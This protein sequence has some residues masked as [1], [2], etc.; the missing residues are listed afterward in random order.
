MQVNSTE[1]QAILAIIQGQGEHEDLVTEKQSIDRRIEA[2]NK[3]RMRLAGLLSDLRPSG[4]TEA[5]VFATR[6]AVLFV[7]GDGA[8]KVSDA[9]L[10]E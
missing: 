6:D 7:Y 9:S 2:F 5:S 8:V 4:K 1:R 10:I 3:E